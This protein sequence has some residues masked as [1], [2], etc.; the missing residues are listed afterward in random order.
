MGEDTDLYRL[1]VASAR[2]VRLVAAWIP[3]L[4]ICDIMG[5]ICNCLC[6]HRRPT[7]EIDLCFNLPMDGILPVFLSF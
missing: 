5:L 2:G 4:C 3:G 7:Y 1:A 6:E